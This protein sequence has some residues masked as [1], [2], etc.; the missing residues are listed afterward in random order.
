M[1]FENF[2]VRNCP[3]Y[4]FSAS[5]YICPYLYL[6][7]FIFVPLYI[8]SCLCLSL[9]IFVSLYIWSDEDLAK[10]KNPPRWR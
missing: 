4:L 1:A 10:V 9:S 8:W 7:L 3:E 2:V 6:S 5:I